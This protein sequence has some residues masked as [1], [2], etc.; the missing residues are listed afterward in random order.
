MFMKLSEKGALCTECGIGRIDIC[1]DESQHLCSIK[2][3]YK[4]GK[5]ELM[6]VREDGAL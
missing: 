2:K 5:K 6:E 4:L 1:P 3:A